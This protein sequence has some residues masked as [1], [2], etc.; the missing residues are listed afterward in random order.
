M[1]ADEQ[2]KIENEEPVGTGDRSRPFSERPEV[3]RSL[4]E[5]AAD[6]FFVHDLEGRLLAANQMACDS[7][8]YACEELLEMRVQD[9][10]AG[11]SAEEL[12]RA[13]GRLAP[14][15][16]VTLEGLH[17]RKDGSVFPVEVRVG[18]LEAEG[19]PLV[20]A[21][22]RDV[23]ERKEAEELLLESE[24]RFRQLFE[25]SVEA[26]LLHDEH[27]NIVDCNAEACRSLGY[28]REEL[29]GLN[30][31]D[32]VVDLIPPEERE[33]RD[34][35]P[36]QRAL[37]G[38]PPNNAVSFHENLHRR[39]DGSTFPVEVGI[40]SIEYGGRRLI[41]ASCRDITERKRL[42]EALA[43]R[44]SHDALTGL[45]NRTLFEERLDQAVSRSRRRGDRVAVIFLDLDGFKPVNDSLGHRTGDLL[46]AAVAERMRACIRKEDT[47]ARIG[48]DEFV[49]LLED[50]TRDEEAV[51][52]ARRIL[53][54]MRRPFVLGDRVVSITASLGVA[55]SGPDLQAGKR[56][57]V[58][59]ADR[60]M[61]RAKRAGGDG[62]RL[63]DAEDEELEER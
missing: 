16:P 24:R 32:F 46:L 55:S 51:G 45:P 42:E 56:D 38:G 47:V 58:S 2:G 26:L 7:L 39:K 19:R 63:F 53:G 21:I 35:T 59:D 41:L 57:L 36:W 52:A 5:Y 27:G 33:L 62:I 54:A 28:S 11:A 4:I 6:A 23:T 43:H 22:A 50:I 40:G 44:A 3:L 10:E 15:R 37:R 14:G 30:L 9:V 31:S 12:A 61:Y 20:L 60:A 34:D 8:G 48:G 13:W 18:L 17:R 25:Q 1:I 29:L 49:V